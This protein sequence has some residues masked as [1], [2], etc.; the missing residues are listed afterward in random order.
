MD[1]FSQFRAFSRYSRLHYQGLLSADGFDTPILTQVA[2]VIS[3]KDDFYKTTKGLC[4]LE[5]PEV[6]HREQNSFGQ[7]LPP[8]KE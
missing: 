7:Y 6:S 3:H 8:S 4:S 2:W 5:C 1:A